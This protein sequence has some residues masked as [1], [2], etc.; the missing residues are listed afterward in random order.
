MQRK[1]LKILLQRMADHFGEGMESKIE[2]N[3]STS[4][5]CTVRDWFWPL[6]LR[7]KLVTGRNGHVGWN[8]WHAYASAKAGE[9]QRITTIPW[10][11]FLV[12][13]SEEFFLLRSL[14]PANL[15]LQ[16]LLDSSNSET[17][18]NLHWMNGKR[19]KSH[20]KPDKLKESKNL[21]TNK[22]VLHVARSKKVINK[23]GTGLGK[24][25]WQPRTKMKEAERRK[26]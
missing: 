5:P 23:W 26:T 8:I 16:L 12:T 2:K 24:G 21:R 15:L 19:R 17:T 10:E 18:W 25:A 9:K 22:I 20:E 7:D 14:W 11:A 3:T 1:H 6:K 13:E 4:K